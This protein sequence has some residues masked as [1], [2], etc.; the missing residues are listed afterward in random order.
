[1][2]GPGR[3]AGDRSH[4]HFLTNPG[5]SRPVHPP[6]GLR[7]SGGGFPP[8]S[9][10]I[11]SAR[12]PCGAG[13][14]SGPKHSAPSE[15][16]PEQFPAIPRTMRM[17]V[18]SCATSPADQTLVVGNRSVPWSGCGADTR[19]RYR[20]PPRARAEGGRRFRPTLHF[21]AQVLHEFGH[22]AFASR[23]FEISRAQEESRDGDELA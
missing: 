3:D 15:G 20:G 8:A 18:P 23:R 5:T 1:M 4:R 21:A 22:R 2:V 14:R 16:T 7:M 6:P 11:G 19:R 10:S 12:V 13:E 9:I 17:A